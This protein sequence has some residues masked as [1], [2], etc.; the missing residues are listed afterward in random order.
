VYDV[1]MEP[2]ASLELEVEY[3]DALWGYFEELTG[4]VE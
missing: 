2:V 3:S 1:D 4:N